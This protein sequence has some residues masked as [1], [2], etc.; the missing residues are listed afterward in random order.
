MVCHSP[1]KG[2]YLP[3]GSGTMAKSKYSKHDFLIPCGKCLGCRFEGARQK[4][5]RAD[6]ERQMHGR[7]CFLTLTYRESDLPYP[8][9]LSKVT[10]QL[11]N[12]RLRMRFSRGLEYFDRKGDPQVLVISEGIRIFYVGEYGGRMFGGKG[13]RE[14]H[15]HYHGIY[16]GCDFPDKKFYKKNKRGDKLYTSDILSELWPYGSAT[17]GS[18][19]FDSAGYCARYSVKKINGAAAV[20]HYTWIDKKTGEF[21]L[22]ESEF[23]E[24]PRGKLGGL[25]KPWFDKY[26]MTDV[27]NSDCVVIKGVETK[28]P[29]YYDNLLKRKDEVLFDSIKKARFDKYKKPELTE[30]ELAAEKAVLEAKARLLYRSIDKSDSNL[31][32]I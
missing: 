27:Y 6:H 29:R 17:I 3:D 22:L 15:P 32:A 12:K 5:V 18:V 9:S 11:F 30:Q 23:C 14:V 28:P 21:H 24:M 7:S 31:G 25:G 10:M 19:N 1:L 8:P 2:I 4:A 20:E 16:F 26:G 13:K